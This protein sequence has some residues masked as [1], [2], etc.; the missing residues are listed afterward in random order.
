LATAP[1]GNTN[2]MHC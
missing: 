1:K 2:L